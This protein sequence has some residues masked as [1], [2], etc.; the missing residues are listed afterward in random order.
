MRST[1]IKKKEVFQEQVDNNLCE[2]IHTQIN[3]KWLRFIGGKEE[4]NGK[5]FSSSF[6]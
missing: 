6:P 1:G 5:I 4:K 2:K 3:I